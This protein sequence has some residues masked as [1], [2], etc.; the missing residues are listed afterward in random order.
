M[1]ALIPRKQARRLSAGELAAPGHEELVDEAGIEQLRVQDRSALAEQPADP[2]L[3][4]QVAHRGALRS[5][6]RPA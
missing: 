3:D 2:A 4:P 5:T 6:R 1:L